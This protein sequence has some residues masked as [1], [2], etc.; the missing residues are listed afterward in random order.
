VLGTTTIFALFAAAA[1]IYSAW[2]FS[3]QLSEIHQASVDTATLARAARD[4][5]N[6]ARE[7]EINGLRAYVNTSQGNIV[8]AP[9]DVATNAIRSGSKKIDE[10]DIRPDI[11]NVIF[12]AV[13]N[14]GQTPAYNVHA[15]I[16][17]S[18]EVLPPFQMLPD[19]FSY[20]DKPAIVL[21]NALPVES[22]TWLGKDQE[23]N[24]Y[25]ILGADA[26][27]GIIKARVGMATV[28]AFMLMVT[29]IMSISLMDP[30]KDP[31]L[32]SITAVTTPLP[33]MAFAAEA[34]INPIIEHNA[35]ITAAN[36]A[37]TART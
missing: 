3:G 35:K 10:I 31:S 29:L 12:I 18:F 11:S 26:M 21:K 16:S 25:A 19:N 28:Y 1:A 33:I 17:I 23:K 15:R 32:S 22:V 27:S 37:R 36:V 20:Q 34:Q 7:T 8:C 13:R 9:C 24:I 6:I 4:Q 5:A 14:F 30:T 2:I